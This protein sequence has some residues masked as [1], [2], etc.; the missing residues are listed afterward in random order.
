VASFCWKTAAPSYKPFAKPRDHW[1]NF[2][3]QR[4]CIAGRFTTAALTSLPLKTMVTPAPFFFLLQCPIHFRAS[5]RRARVTSLV[6]SLRTKLLHCIDPPAC[7]SWCRMEAY[8]YQ[9]AKMKLARLD[10]TQ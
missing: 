3:L 10:S 7:Y 5:A 4:D 8:S 1:L 6:R 9:D 2:V